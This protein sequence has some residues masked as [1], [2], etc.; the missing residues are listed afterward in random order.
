[1][2]GEERELSEKVEAGKLLLEEHRNT[3]YMDTFE[4]CQNWTLLDNRVGLINRWSV[5]ISEVLR[6]L[7]NK[8]LSLVANRDLASAYRLCPPQDLFPDFR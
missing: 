7:E 8:Y 4:Q 6:V 3:K 1:M 2:F 5:R